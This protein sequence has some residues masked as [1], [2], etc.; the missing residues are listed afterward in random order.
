VLIDRTVESICRRCRVRA[1][2]A[3]EFAGYVRVKLMEGD[4]AILKKHRQMCSA[5]TYLRIVIRRLLLDYRTANWGLGR[6]SPAGRQSGP[7]AML[8]DRLMT[9]DGLSFDEAF[10]V[11]QTDYRLHLDR[12]ELYAMSLRLPVRQRRAT[13]GMGDLREL[14]CPESDDGLGH[15]EARLLA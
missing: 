9:R 4:Y 10:N 11:L 6:P 12:D 14:A 1:D 8:L 5:R 13:T 15:A 3:E 2:E 7:T